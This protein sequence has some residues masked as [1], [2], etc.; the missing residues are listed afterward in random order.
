[1]RGRCLSQILFLCGSLFAATTLHAVECPWWDYACQPTEAPAEGTRTIET[2]D[3]TLITDPTREAASALPTDDPNAI[4]NAWDDFQNEMNVLE[5]EIGMDTAKSG[6]CWKSDSDWLT[7]PEKPG[8]EA[9]TIKGTGYYAD[10]PALGVGTVT[11]YCYTNPNAPTKI[12]LR[13]QFCEVDS[14]SCIPNAKCL[15]VPDCL[16]KTICKAKMQ[17]TDVQC[18]AGTICQEGKCVPDSM[19]DGWDGCFVSQPPFLDT[20]GNG[21]P[22]SCFCPAGTYPEDKNND[23]NSDSCTI[24]P[25]MCNA[26]AISGQTYVQKAKGLE[27]GGWTLVDYC[28]NPFKLESVVCSISG[29]KSTSQKPC[30]TG[31]ICFKG[32]CV[33]TDSDLCDNEFANQDPYADKGW[34]TVNSS[35]IIWDKCSSDG[36][37][38]HKIYCTSPMDS[39]V[40]YLPKACKSG[41]YCDPALAKCVLVP[42]SG[43]P[44]APGDGGGN[45]PPPPGGGGKEE[46]PPAPAPIDNCTATMKD[47]CAEPSDGVHPTDPITG[48][49]LYGDPYIFGQTQ[50]SWIY[51][52]CPTLPP[53]VLKKAIPDF[54]IWNESELLPTLI[55]FGC[56]GSAVKSSLSKCDWTKGEACRW[57]KTAADIAEA[58]ANPAQYGV[59]VQK[60]PKAQTGVN[61]N[62]VSGTDVFGRPVNHAFTCAPEQGKKAIRKWKVVDTPEG[63]TPYIDFCPDQ[64]YCKAG[65]CV[66]EPCFQKNSDDSDPCTNDSCNPAT[67]DIYNLPLDSIDDSDPC[68]EDK[69]EDVGGKAA[70]SHVTIINAVCGNTAFCLKYPAD[71]KC[72]T[73]IPPKD[74]GGGGGGTTPPTGG[75]SCDDPA[76]K[77]DPQCQKSIDYCVDDDKLNEKMT[78]GTAVIYPATPQ[79]KMASDTCVE[80]D[81]MTGKFTAV[82][83]VACGPNL[84]FFY[85]KEICPLATTDGCKNGACVPK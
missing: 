20:N 18:K 49:L 80:L 67:G 14:T 17:T 64:H 45:L 82:L 77:D 38:V 19:S 43:A 10:D 21:I 68:T 85:Q 31:Q 39:K 47:G 6:G 60:L 70:I 51:E 37:A 4:P 53:P 16:P 50:P 32:N 1:M 59:C 15:D 27:D 79:E 78:K 12:L 83:Q 2:S 5:M 62:A 24:R 3:T 34:V 35:K 36:K 81:L 74:G 58:I 25:A 75:F 57:P 48:I 42:P 23:G 65:A 33:D 76:N 28:A 63:A 7:S 56:A 55:Q 13:E 40:D 71:P 52:G 46:P 41:D 8:E 29:I 9:Y 61:G 84:T 22:D 44:P 69:C 72:Q 26:S 73:P 66:P 54:C 11:D 30:N